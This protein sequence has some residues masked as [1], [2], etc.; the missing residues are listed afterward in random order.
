MDTIEDDFGVRLAARLRT[1]REARG[2][3]LAELAGRSA[4][5]K[6]MISKVER[7]DSSP[8]A[9]LLG[10]LSGAF[11]LTLSQL[12]AR[13]EAVSGR[14][15]RSAEQPVWRDPET[16]YIRH[17]ATP[18]AAATPLSLVRVELP[19]GA[20]VAYPADAFRFIDQQI[21]VLEGRLDFTQ[22]ETRYEMAAGDCLHLG[23]AADSVF[24]NPGTAPCRY[25]VAVLRTDRP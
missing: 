21:L 14:L 16:G 23:P 24:H 11:G 2:W 3:S 1:E 7:G 19:P 4:V 12:L 10:R 13:A 25:V 17:A 5:S 9:T 22:G 20:R 8:T 6:A 18:E 15:A